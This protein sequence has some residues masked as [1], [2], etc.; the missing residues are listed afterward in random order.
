MADNQI[1]VKGVEFTWH[2]FEL[3]WKNIDADMEQL[4]F[5]VDDVNKVREHVTCFYLEE[6]DDF[7]DERERI[8]RERKK[9][10]RLQRLLRWLRHD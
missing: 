3:V 8:I 9:E 10:T 7:F 1:T 2:E 4:G 5:T 6:I